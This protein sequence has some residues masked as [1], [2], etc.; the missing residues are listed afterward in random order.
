[1]SILDEL[2]HTQHTAY[3]K[4]WGNI[5]APDQDSGLVK[6]LS[7]YQSMPKIRFCRV[8]SEVQPV[9]GSY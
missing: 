9:T 2:P 4:D 5:L 8:T 7:I 6:S 3:P 1:M